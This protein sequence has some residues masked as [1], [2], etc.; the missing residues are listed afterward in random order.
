MMAATIQPTQPKRS[1]CLDKE[2]IAH[3]L[4]CSV[5]S[6]EALLRSG[7][8]KSFVVGRRRVATE[9]SLEQFIRDQERANTN[10]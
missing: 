2:M 9:K 4:A 10:G 8:I 7:K 5:R 1:Q 3:R 6:A